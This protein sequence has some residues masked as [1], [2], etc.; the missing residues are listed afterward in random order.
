L[1]RHVAGETGLAVERRLAAS[2]ARTATEFDFRPL[3]WRGVPVE[4]VC[5]AEGSA[6][7]LPA[8]A[9]EK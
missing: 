5:S 1:P 4:D 2:T 3:E 7:S 6:S 9:S 8:S